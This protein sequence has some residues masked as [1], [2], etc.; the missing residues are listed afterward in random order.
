MLTEIAESV[1]K[2]SKMHALFTHRYKSVSSSLGY[3]QIQ[4]QATIFIPRLQSKSVSQCSPKADGVSGSREGVV[5]SVFV[6]NN[7]RELININPAVTLESL[8][9][10]LAS[11]STASCSQEV[12]RFTDLSQLCIVPV[13]E[14]A[15][16]TFL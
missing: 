14:E 2:T 15:L 13:Q 1:R 10:N 3:M 6:Q 7:L 9:D 8:P 12:L 5:P 16:T 4:I 11:S